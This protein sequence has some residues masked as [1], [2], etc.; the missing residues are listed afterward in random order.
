VAKRDLLPA[1]AAMERADRMPLVRLVRRVGISYA[2]VAGV[3]TI[4]KGAL[5]GFA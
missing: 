4:G 5:D 3:L 1:F 2:A